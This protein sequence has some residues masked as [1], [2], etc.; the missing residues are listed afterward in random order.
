MASTSN[1][2]NNPWQGGKSIPRS[3]MCCAMLRNE[4]IRSRQTPA[5]LVYVY[6]MLV[7]FG[8]RRK[9]ICDDNEVWLDV[10]L[11]EKLFHESWTCRKSY[12]FVSKF[13]RLWRALAEKGCSSS[14]HLLQ[15]KF[16]LNKQQLSHNTRQSNV[17]API[18]WSQI[19][20]SVQFISARLVSDRFPRWPLVGSST[21]TIIDFSHF[22]ESRDCNFS[23]TARRVCSLDSTPR[24]H[25]HL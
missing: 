24:Q 20:F 16:F 8:R 2:T 13:I 15:E 5:K 17:R 23:R 12:C 22:A 19:T 11:A 4:V 10:Q 6:E 25:L 1:C 9:W 21:N 7:T 14:I 3:F 18:A